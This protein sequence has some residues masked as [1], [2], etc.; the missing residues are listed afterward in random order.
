[1]G[2]EGK[3]GSNFRFDEMIVCVF[4]RWMPLQQPRTT[5]SSL[6]QPSRRS[7][8]MTS[9]MVRWLTSSIA[10]SRFLFAVSRYCNH[11][12]RLTQHWEIKE[13]RIR[14]YTRYFAFEMMIKAH[15]FQL[16]N[17]QYIFIWFIFSSSVQQNSSDLLRQLLPDFWLR[18][19]CPCVE[20]AEEDSGRSRYVSR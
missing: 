13:K 15:K 12:H 17:S 18:S 3:V 16:T 9:T 20:C 10:N 14:N 5:V 6:L 7:S 8:A 11:F 19:P 4:P 2:H 1:M